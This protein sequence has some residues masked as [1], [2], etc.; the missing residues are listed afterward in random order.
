MAQ[1]GPAEPLYDLHILIPVP[2]KPEIWA[3]ARAADLNPSQ[4]LRRAIRDQ[5]DRQ[6]EAGR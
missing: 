6:A 4:W 2:M 1:I 3:A 5:L